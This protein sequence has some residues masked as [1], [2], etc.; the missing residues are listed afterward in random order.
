MAMHAGV[1][2][3]PGVMVCRPKFMGGA[4]SVKLRCSGYFDSKGSFR[5]WGLCVQDNNRLVVTGYPTPFILSF[6]FDPFWLLASVGLV[7]IGGLTGVSPPSSD[8]KAAN[9]GARG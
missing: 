4:A 5:E 7:S 3:S 2:W 8:I 6:Y 9:I 1:G